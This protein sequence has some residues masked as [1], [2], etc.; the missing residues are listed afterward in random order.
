MWELSCGILCA[1]LDILFFYN[2]EKIA[3]RKTSLRSVCDCT[4]MKANIQMNIVENENRMKWCNRIF[5]PTSI[6]QNCVWGHYFL[7]QI[8]RPSE[9]TTTKMKKTVFVWFPIHF[10][11]EN[12]KWMFQLCSLL[13][14]IHDNDIF[15][16]IGFMLCHMRP[17]KWPNKYFDSISKDE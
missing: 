6:R 2:D 9:K 10:G 13:F 3:V 7:H 14:C 17:L 12:D 11:L 15:I 5:I 8:D 4:S 1:K 16:W